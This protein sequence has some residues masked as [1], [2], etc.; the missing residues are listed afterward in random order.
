MVDEA[1]GVE[2]N[3]LLRSFGGS[4][5]AATVTGAFWKRPTQREKGQARR[6]SSDPS[7]HAGRINCLRWNPE[8]L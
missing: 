6:D 5:V 2:E 4:N 3:G 1:L 8:K 7:A